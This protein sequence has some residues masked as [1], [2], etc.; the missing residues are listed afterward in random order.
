MFKNGL[1]GDSCADNLQLEN[2]VGRFEVEFEVKF[3]LIVVKC[4]ILT[5]L[6]VQ[7]NGIKYMHSAVQLF[8]LIIIR[9]ISNL[10]FI[11]SWMQWMWSAYLWQALFQSWHKTESKIDPICPHGPYVLVNYTSHYPQLYKTYGKVYHFD[12]IPV[13]W[14]MLCIHNLVPTP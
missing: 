10:F 7:F 1:I 3:F 5:I 13:A 12:K 14:H 11:S 4:K 9:T 8:P 6:R 2:T